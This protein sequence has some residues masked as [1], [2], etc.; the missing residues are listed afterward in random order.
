MNMEI[1]DSVPGGGQQADES[2]PPNFP[3]FQGF[4]NPEIPSTDPEIPEIP[5]THPHGSQMKNG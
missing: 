2:H 3:Q 5:E 4:T 1:W